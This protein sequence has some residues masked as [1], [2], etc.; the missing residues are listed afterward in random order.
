M[1]SISKK[2]RMGLNNP[3]RNADYREKTGSNIGF[4]P[5]FG[6]IPSQSRPISFKIYLLAGNGTD[7]DDL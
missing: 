7:F 4:Y 6:L 1:G 2:R 3:G 5:I